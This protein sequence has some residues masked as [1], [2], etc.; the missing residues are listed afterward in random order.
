MPDHSSNHDAAS[1]P[2]RTRT[3]VHAT[4]AVSRRRKIAI[5]LVLMVCGYFLVD[6]REP[7]PEFSNDSDAIHDPAI[8]ELMQ[9]TFEIPETPA[10]VV[11]HSRTDEY[12]PL[13]LPEDDFEVQEVAHLDPHPKVEPVFPEPRIATTQQP[14]P[15]RRRKPASRPRLRFTG[16]IEPLY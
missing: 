2:V 1:E 10:A 14:A 6:E 16:E 3:G 15:Q 8:E 4:A 11:E 12:A 5:V 9:D 13:Q 7:P